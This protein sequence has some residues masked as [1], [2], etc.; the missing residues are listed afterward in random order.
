MNKIIQFFQ[1][2]VVFLPVILPH[3]HYYEFQ[4]PFQEYFFETAN[5]GI[6]NALHF[7]VD[8]PKGVLLYFH[9]N[10]DN[11]HRWGKIASK[12]TQFKYDVLVMDYRGYGKSTGKRTEENMFTDAQFCYD[13]LKDKYSE[14]KIIIYGRSLGGAFAT[15]IASENSPK[16]VILESTFY[17]LQDM[18]NR[19]IPNT[20]TNILSPI[21]PYHF[22][23]NEYIKK[24]KAPLYHF[25]GT[26]DAV[27]PI[28]SGRKLFQVFEEYQPETPKKFIEIIGGKH[29]NLEHFEIFQHEIYRILEH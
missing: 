20:I 3:H 9:G 19:L 5:E 16:K 21:F 24:I 6:I 13:F 7:H 18:A 23:S 28:K 8:K 17:N 14:N 11:L 4:N 2:K 15:K 10:A 27:V 29:D 1:E 12:F 22:L 26:K 25:H